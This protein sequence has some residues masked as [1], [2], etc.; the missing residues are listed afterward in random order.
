MAL[1]KSYEDIEVWKRG[2]RLVIT[3]YE[4]TNH[5]RFSR[6]F[7]LRDQMRRAAISIPSNVAEGFERDSKAEFIRFLYIAKGSAGE[8]RTQIY[9]AKKLKYLNEKEYETIVEELREVSMML[10]GLIRKLRESEK[11]GKW[12]SLKV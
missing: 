1:F 3:I 2:S 9:I 10:A 6:D 12:E 7:G 11:V 4:L 5:D 8:L